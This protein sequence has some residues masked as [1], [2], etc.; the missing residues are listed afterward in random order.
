MESKRA[1]Y[2]VRQENL[3]EREY[4]E[5]LEYM[6]RSGSEYGPQGSS[7]EHG[8]EPSGSVTTSILKKCSASRNY[9]VR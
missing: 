1:T 2:R 7:F 4:C 3:K 6:I 9:S 5:D 8:N